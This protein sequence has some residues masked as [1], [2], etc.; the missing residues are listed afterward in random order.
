MLSPQLCCPISF[1]IRGGRS[2]NIMD[3]SHGCPTIWYQPRRPMI[4]VIW[5]CFSLSVMYIV[6][7]SFTLQSRLRGVSRG[8]FRCSIQVRQGIGRW[9]RPAGCQCLSL[10][11][12]F[13]RGMICPETTQ[14]KRRQSKSYSN[15]YFGRAR[16][17]LLLLDWDWWVV[18][19]ETRSAIL[20]LRP[21]CC[22]FRA[23]I[24]PNVAPYIETLCY[25]KGSNGGARESQSDTEKIDIG[26]TDLVTSPF[27][28]IWFASCRGLRSI[29]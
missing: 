6:S 29:V 10:C 26:E 1:I 21:V 13:L 25:F 11:L 8:I 3:C 14:Y 15:S 23:E 5:W 22:E 2:L 24:E 17:R 7:S 4:R 27:R 20:D 12:C 9:N 18:T 19:G 16:E 28:M